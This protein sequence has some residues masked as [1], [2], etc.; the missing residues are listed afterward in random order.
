MQATYSLFELHQFLRRVVALNFPEAV[1]IRAELVQIDRHRGH[2]FAELADKESE[3]EAPQAQ[4]RAI[5]WDRSY[6]KLRRAHGK[7]LEQLLQP[8][9]SVQLLVQ[10]RFHEQYGYSLEIQD[11]D[12]AFTLG[13]LEQRR[14]ATIQTLREGGDFDRQAQLLLPP[15]LQRLAVVTSQT[16]AGLADFETTLRENQAGYAFQ[17]DL[18]EATVQGIQASGTMRGRL[19]QLARR[20]ASYD[21]VI[22]LRGGGARLDLAAFDELEL[23][24]VAARHPLPIL[25]GIGHETDISILDQVAHRAFRTPTAVAEWILQHQATFEAQLIDQLEQI[26]RAAQLRV[27]LQ[28]QQ[29]QQTENQ[30]RQ[31]SLLQLHRHHRNLDRLADQL[32]FLSQRA[33]AYRRQELGFLQDLLTAIH[34]DAILK[35]GYSLVTQQRTIIRDSEQVDE[36]RPIKIQFWKG[37]VVR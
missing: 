6:R 35:R 12:P 9:L 32:P 27:Q 1:W 36:A 37:F 25:T 8:G 30:L 20:A 31:A 26:A 3:G 28:Y 24:Q 23:C 11:V 13:A 21:A 29:L 7:L 4:A 2:V 18:F 17:I 33:L 5:I 34:P 14:R 15:V 16:A 10:V 22:L 19:Q